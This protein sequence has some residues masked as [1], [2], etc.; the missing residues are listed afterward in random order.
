MHRTDEEVCLG[1]GHHPVGDVPL[2]GDHADGA[3]AQCEG[4]PRCGRGQDALE[5]FAGLGQLSRQQWLAAMHFRAD[6]GCDQADDAFA[7]RF[8]QLHAHW[9]APR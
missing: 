4:R 1:A 6:V 7:V 8:G 3:L 2:Q 5:A 9:R